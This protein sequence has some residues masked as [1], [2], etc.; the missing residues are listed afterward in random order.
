[1][2]KSDWLVM[3]QSND[4]SVKPCKDC[5]GTGSNCSTCRGFGY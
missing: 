2:R 1:M 3:A 5:K 4:S